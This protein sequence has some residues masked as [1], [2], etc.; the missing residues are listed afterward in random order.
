MQELG[1]EIEP[2]A[3]KHRRTDVPSPRVSRDGS[4]TPVGTRP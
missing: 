3:Q 1:D 2:T 4:P